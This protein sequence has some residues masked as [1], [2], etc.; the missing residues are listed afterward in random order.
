MKS[1]EKILVLIG[2]ADVAL[3]NGN[4]E[5]EVFESP[6]FILKLLHNPRFHFHFFLQLYPLSLSSHEAQLNSCW[7]S[8]LSRFLSFGFLGCGAA[9]DINQH[10]HPSF[11]HSSHSP[12]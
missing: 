10:R 6:T 3:E 1:N 7:L 11:A 5:F 12:S 4:R 2:Y 9:W 8:F